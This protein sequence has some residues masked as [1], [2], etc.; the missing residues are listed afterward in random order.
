MEPDVEHGRTGGCLLLLGCPVNYAGVILVDIPPPLLAL[1]N[2][3][4]IRG[5]QKALVDLVENAD[6]IIVSLDCQNC[7]CPGVPGVNPQLDRQVRVELYWLYMGFCKLLK[8]DACNSDGFGTDTNG[9][10]LG[11]K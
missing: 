6:L 7:I 2:T 11:V 4:N 5:G 10:G 9:E 1:A 3:D 8:G